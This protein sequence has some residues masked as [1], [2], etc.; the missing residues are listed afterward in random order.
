MVLI[1]RR[2]GVCVL[3]NKTQSSCSLLWAQ[4]S[5]GAHIV[6]GGASGAVPTLARPS[7]RIW[8]QCSVAPSSFFGSANI[9]FITDWQITIL[10]QCK[11]FKPQY[12]N[13]SSKRKPTGK[14]RHS[15]NVGKT[16]YKTTRDVRLQGFKDQRSTIIEVDKWNRSSSW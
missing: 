7:I 15:L 6:M 12:C 16:K 5:A 8:S 2:D 1:V 4:L 11:L 13:Q 9:L 14:Y 3:L 10:S